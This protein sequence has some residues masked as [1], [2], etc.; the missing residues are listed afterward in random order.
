VIANSGT[1]VDSPNTVS[2]P[3]HLQSLCATGARET[4][5]RAKQSTRN[6]QPSGWRI[7]TRPNTKAIGSG[8]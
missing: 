3:S 6:L 1:V 7:P 5:V 4:R 8:G 2:G